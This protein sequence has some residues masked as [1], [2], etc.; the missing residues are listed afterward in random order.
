MDA[1]WEVQVADHWLN[2][3]GFQSLPARTIALAGA[4]EAMDFVA[5]RIIGD[6]R[7][8]TF[9]SP[10]RLAGGEFQLRAV[11]QTARRYRIDASPDLRD[12]TAVST[13]ATEM[14][15]FIFT[16]HQ[17]ATAPRRFYRAALLE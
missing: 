4:N 9:V 16:D 11:S 17:R 13:N 14:G 7:A 6:G 10:M 3:L 1:N 8:L 12:W 15:S 5:Q 2:S